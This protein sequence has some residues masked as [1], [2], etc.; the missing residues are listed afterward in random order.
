MSGTLSP[1]STSASS[2]SPAS[3]REPGTPQGLLLVGL[4]CLAVLG[5]VLIAPI[6]PSIARHFADTPGVGA[7][8]PISLTV[9][10][11]AIALLA[12]VAGRIID[13]TGRIR[14]LVASLVAYAVFGTAPLWLDSLE[15]I[16]ASRALVGVAEAG[17]MTC[18]TA[19]V[20]DYFTGRRRNRYFGLQTVAASVSAV[21]FI[22]AGGALGAQ[23][24]RTPFWLYAVGLLGAV[25]VPFVLRE[26]AAAPAGKLPPLDLERLRL[27]LAVTFVGGIVFYTPIVELSFA[28]DALG[29][30]SVAVIGGVS[31]LAAVATAVGA[32]SFAP[33]A[34]RGPAVLLPVAFGLAGVGLVVVALAPSVPVLLAGG[35][36]ASAGTG[37]MLPTLLS[38]TLS[39][40]SHDQRGR[41]T[42]IW[43]G[44]L[45]IGEFICPLAVLAMS[46]VLGGLSAALVAIAVLSLALAVFVR[47]RHPRPVLTH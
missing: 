36:I 19:L 45:F 43:T 32:A 8:V 23:D 4:S 1:D 11:L 3:R 17:I 30:E 35:I 6:Q 9:P 28:L 21:I 38:W 13:R 33:M 26:P 25:L 27:P 14:L 24:W 29:V 31:A 16:V 15:S 42:G 37:L 40:V 2:A 18:A 7:L 10:A 41:A 22:G 47:L 34:R 5:A 46:A 12:P 39:D 20:G 44:C